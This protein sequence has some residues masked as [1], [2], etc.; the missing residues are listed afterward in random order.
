M[1][2]YGVSLPLVEYVKANNGNIIGDV[3][4]L[5]AGNEPRPAAVGRDGEFQFFLSDPRPVVG[6]RGLRAGVLCQ[7]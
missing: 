5:S 7:A 3:F 4:T 6:P 1:P 2:S